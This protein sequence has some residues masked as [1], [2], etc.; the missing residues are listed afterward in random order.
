MHLYIS[1][2]SINSLKN[3]NVNFKSIKYAVHFQM[4]PGRVHFTV[5]YGFEFLVTNRFCTFQGR[6]VYLECGFKCFTFFLKINYFWNIIYKNSIYKIPLAYYWRENL[7]TVFC[8]RIHIANEKVAFWCFTFFTNAYSSL[9]I[10]VNQLILK[11]VLV[12]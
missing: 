5:D 2:M 12:C 1:T 7:F 3:K 9:L 11:T 10:F 4:V 8:Y 6:K